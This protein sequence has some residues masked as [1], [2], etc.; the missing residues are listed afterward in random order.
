LPELFSSPLTHLARRYSAK[1]DPYN[2]Y[3]QHLFSG[4]MPW[5]ETIHELF[6]YKDMLS[7]GSDPAIMASYGQWSTATL[8]VTVVRTP[9]FYFW[10]FVMVVIMLVFVS[11]FSFSIPKQSLDARLGLTLTVVLGLNVFQIVI[12]DNVSS[13]PYP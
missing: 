10:N 4:E 9:D 11:F 7:N 6:P 12:I 8:T 2:S 5:N 3:L 13:T 1:H